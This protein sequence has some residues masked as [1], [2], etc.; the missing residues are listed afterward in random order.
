MTPITIVILAAVVLIVARQF[1]ARPMRTLP[2]VAVPLVLVGLGLQGTLAHH[3]GA[4]G[5]VLAG[6]SLAVSA[7]LGALR[8]RSER[9]WRTADGTLFR[10]GTKVTAGL[11]LLSIAIRLVAVGLD[12]AAGVHTP[13]GPALEL[14]LGASLAVQ[15]A[16]IASRAGLIGPLGTL[17]A[18][19]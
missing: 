9:V 5:A 8:G 16:V 15:H 4:T 11:W 12:R 14:F 13:T 1:M 10:Q 19:R 18:A 2:L 7:G 6:V 17:R 3:L